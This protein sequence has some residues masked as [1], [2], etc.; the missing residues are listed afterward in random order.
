MFLFPKSTKRAV[1]QFTA[2][3]AELQAVVS[4]NQAKVQKSYVNDDTDISYINAFCGALR[5]WLDGRRA[6]SI[7][8]RTANRAEI[9]EAC[10]WLDALPKIKK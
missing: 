5:S 4:I 3:R 8:K 6:K 2:A 9:D 7:V 10:A 1:K